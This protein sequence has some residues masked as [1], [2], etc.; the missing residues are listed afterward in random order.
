MQVISGE[1]KKISRLKI[2]RQ[3]L[4]QRKT[5]ASLKGRSGE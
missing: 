5:G 4:A 2:G 1:Y 3:D